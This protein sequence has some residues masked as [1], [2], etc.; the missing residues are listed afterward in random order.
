MA[1]T[2]PIVLTFGG[3]IHSRRRISDIDIDECVAG[4]ENFDLEPQFLALTPRKPFDQVGTAPNAGSIRGYA[5]LCRTDGSLSTLIQA[6]DRVYSWNGSTGFT[7]VGQVNATARLRGGIEH[8]FLLENITI[9]TDLERVETVKKWDGT[10]FAQFAHDLGGDFFAKFCR[11]F[12]E[13]AVLAN[14]KTTTDTPHVALFSKRGDSETLTTGNRPSSGLGLDDPFF[15]PMPDLKPINGLEFAFGE[16]LFSTERG[17]LYRLSGSSALD[18]FMEELYNIK[19]VVGDEAVINIGNDLLLGLPG[20][21]ETLSGV[22]EFGD[23][24]AN[25]VSIEIADQVEDVQS[26]RLFYDRNREHVYAFGA[27]QSGVLILHKRL[28]D[29]AEESPWSKWTTTQS[30]A[31]D[32]VTVMPIIDPLTMIDAIYM[33]DENGNIYR[34]QGS[35]DKDGGTDAVT[36]KRRTGL[37]EIPAGNAFDLKGWISYRKL[38][39]TLVTIRVLYGGKEE[40]TQETQTKLPTNTNI[41]VYGG[42][43]YYG[44]NQTFYGA[45]FSQRI[46]I[47][48]WRAA[49][50][51]S[52]FQIEVEFD[53]ESAVHIEEIGF[54][55]DTQDTQT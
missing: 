30:M 26:W 31:F 1:E 22:L 25:D 8:N 40:F 28:L 50:L 37:I 55:F 32:P 45:E 21:I 11:I 7:E 49:G 19:S 33:G 15:L 39:E 18:Y 52:H 16:L 13:R 27:N 36:V 14:V 12:G 10:T 41:A 2:E 44:D 9:I 35:G 53:A 20:R 42:A 3:G 4:S 54:S 17:R 38:F 5:Q 47:Q 29:Q 34:M 24:Q 23:V 6:R 51:S 48:D 46:A 43:H